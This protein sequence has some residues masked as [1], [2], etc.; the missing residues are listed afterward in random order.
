M[1]S[2]LFPS[3]ILHISTL[4]YLFSLLPLFGPSLWKGEC[5]LDLQYQFI[6]FILRINHTVSV[7]IYNLLSIISEFYPGFIRSSW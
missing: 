6:F 5:H 4:F 7:L 2:Q 3:K 1:F